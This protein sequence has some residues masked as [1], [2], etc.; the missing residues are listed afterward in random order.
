MTVASEHVSGDLVSR[1]DSLHTRVQAIQPSGSHAG[2]VWVVYVSGNMH[3]TTASQLR[4]VVRE[5]IQSVRPA[6]VI[7]DLSGVTH[8]DSSGMGA[9]VAILRD[10]NHDH[11]PLLLVGLSGALRRQ[12]ERT[13]LHTIF[14]IRPTVRDAVCL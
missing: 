9:L 6:R 12:L 7:L 10:A 4:V 1:F 14:D 3:W 5:L 13:Q 8:M 2:V 11:V